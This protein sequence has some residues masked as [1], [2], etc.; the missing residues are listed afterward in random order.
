MTPIHDLIK[1][2]GVTDERLRTAVD[3]LFEALTFRPPT[4]EESGD[5]LQVVKNSID[6]VGKEKGVFM[7]LSAIFL[8]G[9]RFLSMVRYE[10]YFESFLP[11]AP[12]EGEILSE[13]L[14]EPPLVPVPVKASCSR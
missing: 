9:T 8:C 6:K 1:E 13:P 5:Y 3:F 4:T 2:E 10:P 14:L 12:S 11:I 7:G